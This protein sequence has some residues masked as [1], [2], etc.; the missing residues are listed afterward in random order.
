VCMNEHVLP[1]YL[2]AEKKKELSF[3]QY[4]T[5]HG[6]ELPANYLQE[7]FHNEIRHF[8]SLL[9]LL[10]INYSGI[11]L[12]IKSFQRLGLLTRQTVGFFELFTKL[13]INCSDESISLNYYYLYFDTEGIPK[14]SRLEKILIT[15]EKGI[16]TKLT[17]Q[18]WVEILGSK[19]TILTKKN[20]VDRTT[21]SNLISLNAY[22]RLS[23]K[24]SPRQDRLSRGNIPAIIQFIL[25]NKVEGV[26][27][28]KYNNYTT[29]YASP[30]TWAECIKL[31]RQ[32]KLEIKKTRAVSCD[33]FFKYIVKKQRN[34]DLIEVLEYRLLCLKPPE[35]VLQE[36][37]PNSKKLIVK[38]A[39]TTWQELYD[40]YELLRGKSVEKMMTLPAYVKAFNQLVPKG[41][42]QKKVRKIAQHMAGIT[43]IDYIV[44]RNTIVKA[45]PEDWQKVIDYYLSQRA[46]VI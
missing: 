34:P 39:V 27:W 19:T 32:D 44:N 18:K 26:V 17:V 24:P 14:K 35:Y 15:L 11:S 29:A 20:L 10:G 22:T 46:K 38:A 2:S 30:E 5:T 3:A 7:K 13:Y 36:Y 16:T 6:I 8:I 21:T 28:K 12:P 33:F 41:S 31:F 42:A 43:V 23:K 9:E 1:D 4:I 37:H 25:D 40:D 45:S